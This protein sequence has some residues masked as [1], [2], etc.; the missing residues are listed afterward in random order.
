[1]GVT[2]KPASAT[3]ATVR[4]P[5]GAEAA[6]EISLFGKPLSCK[7]CKAPYKVV[8][9]VDP[10]S[11]AR[12]A[13]VVPLS[14]DHPALRIPKGAQEVQCDCGQPLVARRE[15]AGKPVKCP[16][17]GRSLLLEKYKDP[18]TLE[19]RIR[20]APAAPARKKGDTSTSQEI[21]CACGEYL[22][23]DREVIGKQAQCGACG[24]IMMLDRVQDPQTRVTTVRATIVGKVDKPDP[25]AWSLEDFK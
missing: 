13:A 17:C 20:R 16:D 1:L 21:L 7:A 23:V 19:T 18:Q 4:C 6:V 14:G 2:T 25:D 10:K 5:C 11:K 9:A 24:S 3:L 22:R 8:W 12:V 15:Q